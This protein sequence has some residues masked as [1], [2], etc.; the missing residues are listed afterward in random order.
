MSRIVFI[1]YLAF[2]TYASS[3]QNSTV[4]SL[5]TIDLDELVI[6]RSNILKAS[7]IGLTQVNIKGHVLDHHKGSS[8]SELMRINSTGQLRAYGPGGLSTPSFR[9]IGGSHTA[10]LWNGINIASPLAGQQDLSQIPIAAIDNIQIQKGGSASLYGSGALGGSIQFNNITQFNEAFNFSGTHKFGSFGDHYQNY[11]VKW[12]NNKYSNSTSFFLRNLDNDYPF[13]NKYT[14]PERLEKRVH[15]RQKQFGFLQQNAWSVNK[16]HLLSLKFWH[17]DNS[18]EVPNSILANQTSKA[19]QRDKYV[20]VLLSWNV[21]KQN[22]SFSY[23]QAL[24]SHQLNYIDPDKN[25][26]SNSNYTSWINRIENETQLTNKIEIVTGINHTYETTEV[27]NFGDSNPSRNNTALYGSF[28]FHDLEDK[29]QLS[30]NLREEIIDSDF[31]PFSPSF[32]ISYLTHPNVKLNGNI[33]RNYR[34]PTF[35]DLY[36]KGES[37][38]NPNLLS[39]TSWNQEGGIEINHPNEIL[40]AQMTLYSSLIDNWIQWTPKSGT[41]NQWTPDNVKQV[42]SRGLETRL[43]GILNGGLIAVDWNASYNFTKTTNNKIAKGGGSTGK[44]LSYTPMHDANI[45]VT[46]SYK[47]ISWTFL[48]NYTGK[49]FTDEDNSELRALPSYLIIGTYLKRT[50][51]FKSHAASLLLKVNNLLDKSYENRRGYPM[52]GRNFSITLNF[53]FKQKSKS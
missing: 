38:G 25:L 39:E 46:A 52:Y 35:N 33:S 36:W 22:L 26:D 18:Y 50:F 7:E 16:H 8:F 23:K 53:K 9:G 45:Y 21:D 29:L 2:Y 49:Q 40:N 51:K 19:I 5:K 42:W 20:R 32:G 37:S 43:S 41:S 4:D 28:R 24:I 6:E 12:S 17:Q 1:V 30:V 31:T 10:V 44:Q 48:I 11:Q 34:V 14:H 3:A 13:T 27:D 15:S 47:K